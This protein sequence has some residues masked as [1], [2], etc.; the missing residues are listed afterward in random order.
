MLTTLRIRD[1]AIVDDLTVE[2][3]PGLNLLTGETGAGKSIVV[4]ALGL[5]AG[6]RGDS[7][8]VRSG[9][10]RAVIE[11]VIEPPDPA[12]LGK[13]LDSRGVDTA[14]DGAVLLRREVAASGSGR[15]F[16][17][18]SPA[19][20]A[21]LREIAAL[22]LEIHGQHEHQ[23]LL[24][25]D[26]HLELLDRFGG[27][28]DEREAVRYAHRRVE[29]AGRELERLR[30]LAEDSRRRAEELRRDI[31]EIDA[32]SPR[33]GERDRLDVERRRLRHGVEIAGRVEDVVA[34]LYEDD[35]SASNRVATAT[36]GAERLAELD[37]TLAGLAE[38][39]RQVQL[40]LEDVGTALR[41]YRDRGDFDPARL[42]ELESRRAALDRLCLLYGQDEDAVLAHRERAAGE[43]A[44][45]DHLDEALAAAERIRRERESEY[46]AA[47]RS[48]GVARRKAAKAM[49]PVLR[50]QLRALAFR[51]A[52]FEVGFSPANGRRVEGVEGETC[53]LSPRGAERAEFLLSTNPGEATRPL[54]KIASGGELSRVMLALH[55]ALRRAAGRRVLVFDEVDAGIGGA[56]ADAVGARLAELSEDHQV[57]CVTHLPQVAAYAERHYHVQ[58]ATR[59][60]RTTTRVIPLTRSGRLDELARML[61]GRQVSSASRRNAE[62]LLAAVTREPAPP[63]RRA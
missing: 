10:R 32:V 34:S 9:A 27:H 60:G 33:A 58:K 62:A 56:T 42:E 50:S 16:V 21:V 22:L 28:V 41:D 24:S 57:L 17:N 43:L 11:A 36:R 14:D 25:P 55:V 39:L 19:A 5:V 18:G 3:G 46:G 6:R 29:E 61:G 44:E 53:V 26:Q 15:V 47:A 13:L 63:R 38:R 35:A 4:D 49:A 1:L 23:S 37:P 20:V 2:F 12:E 31:R 8:M 40:E 51:H 52:R 54:G 7:A 59:V 45:L 30:G 48:L